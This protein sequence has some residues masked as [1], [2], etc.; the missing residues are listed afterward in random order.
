[1]P[2]NNTSVSP[3]VIGVT[4]GGR[5]LVSVLTVTTGDIF[6]SILGTTVPNLPA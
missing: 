5:L 3:I 6:D 1:M 4:T 2:T